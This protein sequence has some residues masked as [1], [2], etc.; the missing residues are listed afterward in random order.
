MALVSHRE[1]NFVLTFR[2]VVLLLVV[3]CV[4]ALY[5]IRRQAHTPLSP[6][7]PADLCLPWRDNLWMREAKAKS[8][9]LARESSLLGWRAH[10]GRASRPIWVLGTAHAPGTTHTC[11]FSN[12]RVLRPLA[13]FLS[14]ACIEL[15]SHIQ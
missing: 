4:V 1:S 7:G 13:V 5:S 2:N 11:R 6:F 3:L 8:F 12:P 14:F 9:G 15:L 10:N